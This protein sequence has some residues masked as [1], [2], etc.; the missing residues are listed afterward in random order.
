MTFHVVCLAWVFFRAE[1]LGDAFELLWRLV[2]APGGGPLVKP[3]LMFVIVAMIAWGLIG[4]V[5]LLG[6]RLLFRP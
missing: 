4:M 5:T 6:L 1:T 2:A 3:M